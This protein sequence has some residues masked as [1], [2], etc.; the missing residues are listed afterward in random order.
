M[1]QIEINDLSNCKKEINLEIPSETI[2]KLREIETKKMQKKAQL[3]GFRKGKVPRKMVIKTYAATIEQNTIDEAINQVYKDILNDNKLNP[4]D[5]PVLVDIKYD[6][7]KNLVAKLE[8][9]TFP[10]IELKKYKNIKLTKTIYKVEDKDI[11]A[12]FERMKHEKAIISPVDD[13]AEN[14]HYVSMEMQELDE[15]GI[16]LI[17]KKYPDFRVQLG[18]GKFDEDL[19][20]QLLGIKVGDERRIEKVYSKNDKNK[21]LAGKTEKYLVKVNKVENEEL[22]EIDDEFIKELNSD[23]KTVAEMREKVKENLEHSFA[24]KSEQLFYNQLAHELLQENPFDIPEKMVD[25]YLDRIVED[26]KNRDKSI[27]EEKIRANYKTD[28][29]FNMKWFYLKNRIAEEENIKVTE[30]DI[31]DYLK[32]IEDEKMR[33]MFANN[34]E[35]KQRISGDLAERKII[36]FLIENQKITEK[37]ESVK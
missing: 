5:N 2:D 26:I 35:W 10:E 31:E 14:G 19:E 8:V 3:P 29:K 1:S 21:E 17:G 20:K 15:Q 7:D 27:D 37:V 4:I 28:A 16:P 32:S 25:D 12:V 11:D 36:N 9:E 23:V 24:D 22:P 18:S 34:A 30:K 13:G 33:E 6:D